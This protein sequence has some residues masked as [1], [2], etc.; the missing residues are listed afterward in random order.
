MKTKSSLLV[1]FLLIAGSIIAQDFKT[2]SLEAMGY[3][4]ESI[5]GINGAISYFLKVQPRDDVDR[6]NLILQVKPSQV[7]REDMSTIT[8]S[9]KDEPVY[10]TR[11]VADAIDSVMT[12][13]IPLNKRYV[14]EDGRFIKMRIDAKM[15]MSDEYCKDVDNPAIW[16]TVRNSSYLEVVKQDRTTYYHSLKETISEFNS[17][18]T[19]VNAD[20]D[21]LTSGAIVFALLK[22]KGGLEDIITNNYRNTDSSVGT[23]VL[24]GLYNKLPAYIQ[25]QLPEFKAGQGLIKNVIL[26]NGDYIFV[27]TGKDQEGYRK[28]IYTLTN[29]KI[30]NGSFTYTMIVDAGPPSYF[31]KNQLPVVFSLEELG[32]TPKLME[33]IGALKTNYA[34]SLADY[35]AIPKK[36]TFHL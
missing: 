13:V 30:I 23:T 15:A 19:P 25:A 6:T 16:V 29:Y 36:L 8:V 33:G 22:Q 18:S 2:R 24:T 35:N 34:F 4:N 5:M 10:T 7:L 3:R 26:D 12:I 31:D 14:Q 20:L 21:D 1:L 28:A 11:L 27:I 17:V 32:G 9:L